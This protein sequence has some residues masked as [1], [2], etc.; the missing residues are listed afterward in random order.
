MYPYCL[1]IEQMQVLH[2]P[3]AGKSPVP[4]KSFHFSPH[5]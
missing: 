5:G 3:D 4:G 2:D 1:L